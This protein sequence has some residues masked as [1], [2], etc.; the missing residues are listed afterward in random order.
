MDHQESVFWHDDHV[1]RHGDVARSRGGNTID[2]DGDVAC[3]ALQRVVNRDR[4]KHRA[5][6]AVE[7]QINGRIIGQRAQFCQKALRCDAV[8]ADFVI[9]Q[10]FRARGTSA[11]RVPG[12]HEVTPLRGCLPG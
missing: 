5:A 3:M 7:A 4:V 6:R 11:D 8:S 12:F 10:H 1:A 2:P 9:D